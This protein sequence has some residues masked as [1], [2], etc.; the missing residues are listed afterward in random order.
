MAINTVVLVFGTAVSL[1]LLF[2]RF[3]GFEKEA[4]GGRYPHL[5][6]SRSFYWIS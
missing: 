6:G 1:F 3:Q 2:F 5:E 4:A